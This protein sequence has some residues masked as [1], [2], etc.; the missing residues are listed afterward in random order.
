MTES[1]EKDK[2]E[3]PNQRRIDRRGLIEVIL[4]GAISLSIVVAL[5]D[6]L[7]QFSLFLASIN[8]AVHVT[9]VF[10]KLGVFKEL[11]TIFPSPKS[12]AVTSVGLILIVFAITA[13]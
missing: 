1:R 10:T 2:K 8:I 6:Y 4:A 11:K 3:T 12:E 9:L 5:T 13:L 7:Q